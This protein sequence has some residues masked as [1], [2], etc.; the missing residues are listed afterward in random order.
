M[1]MDAEVNTYDCQKHTAKIRRIEELAKSVSKPDTDCKVMQLKAYRF[2]SDNA[3]RMANFQG[4]SLE[5]ID[6]FKLERLKSLVDFSYENVSFY[7]KLY[8]SIGYE[9]GSIRNVN[10]FMKLPIVT[11]RQMREFDI[12][13][14]VSSPDEIGVTPSTRTS[15][16]S[17]TPFISYHSESDIVRDYSEVLRFYNGCLKRPLEANDWIYMIHHAGLW[18]SSFDGKY[19]TFQLPD[20]FTDTPLNKHLDYIGPRIISTL[21]SYLPV[22]KGM[23]IS[24][25]D[26]GV[27]VIITNSEYSSRR[28]REFYAKELGIP[29]FDEYSSEEFGLIA[30]QCAEG[31]YHVV[32]DGVHVE[33]LNKDD[34]GLGSVVCTDLNNWFMP[35]I[36]FE[37][38][39]LA[40]EINPRQRCNCGREGMRFSEVNGRSDDA[41]LTI[42]N[43]IVPSASILA[44]VDDILV[45]HD[46]SLNEFRVIQ[47]SATNITLQTV[48]SGPTYCEMHKLLND[49]SKRLVS[50]FGYPVT[51]LH[52]EVSALP[53]VNSYK[54]KCLVREWSVSRYVPN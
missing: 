22:I 20:L 4:L 50:L 29:I 14:R 3:A 30:T 25:K 26:F 45:E 15:G 49:F 37:H 43:R 44:A 41:F 11:K 23:G 40:R 46:L 6:A 21:P 16:S 42:D 52:Q 38:G 10:D 28:E 1:S 7:R 48:Y 2:W 9:V 13:E 12:S 19:R 27:E 51:L 36:R 18:I 54:R 32:E 5:E 35:L 31:M 24:L 8:S 34:T 47:T 39:D 53:D 17:G 33:I